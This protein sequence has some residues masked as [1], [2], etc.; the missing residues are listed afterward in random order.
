MNWGAVRPVLKSLIA[1]LSGL[2]TNWEDEPRGF[3]DTFA[4]LTITSCVGVGWDECR[5]QQDLTQPTG[6]ELQ[7][8]W[9]G[10]R[11]MTLTVKVESLIQTDTGNA[12]QYLE[13][14]RDKL[15][16]RGSAARCRAVNVAIVDQGQTVD[17]PMP[18]DDRM[19]SI[20]SLDIMLSVRNLIIDPERYPFIGTWN[21]SG[22]LQDP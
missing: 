20:A 14:V 6:L 21:A 11:N 8:V 4:T 5:T 3:G 19:R 2:V 16:F 9:I 12:Y 13:L 17:L 22:T 7:D 10:N 15:W 18:R 1:D